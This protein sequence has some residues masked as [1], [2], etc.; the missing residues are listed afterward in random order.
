[1]G[2][3]CGLH[4]GP[5]D[6]TFGLNIVSMGETC[7]PH[8]SPMEFVKKSFARRNFVLVGVD[9]EDE[10]EYGLEELSW[11]KKIKKI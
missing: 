11:R 9:G 3:M 7:M 4:V 2:L 6:T 1:M 10:R 8:V 5:M